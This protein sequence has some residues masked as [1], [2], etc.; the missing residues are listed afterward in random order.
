M[1]ILAKQITKQL[2]IYIYLSPHVL[3]KPKDVPVSLLPDMIV[4]TPV[5]G[6]KRPA[7]FGVVFESPERFDMDK[8]TL[9]LTISGIVALIREFEP[10]AQIDT[11]REDTKHHLAKVVDY[12]FSKF[13]PIFYG[14]GGL[15]PQRIRIT[16]GNCIVVTGPVVDH[17]YY[18]KRGYY[19]LRVYIAGLMDTRGI[20]FHHPAYDVTLSISPENAVKLTGEAIAKA[21]PNATYHVEVIDTITGPYKPECHGKDRYSEQKEALNANG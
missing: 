20:I 21:L 1:K 13:G 5:R 11:L 8:D 2:K 18:S 6:C 9:N 14:E 10:N 4:R 3:G 16:A 12:K 19:S 7:W 17:L 15:I